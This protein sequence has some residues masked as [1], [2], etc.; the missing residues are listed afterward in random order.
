MKKLMIIAILLLVSNVVFSQTHYYKAKYEKPFT[1][2]V[3]PT[4]FNYGG[5]LFGYQI[6][7]NFKE[8]FN[9]SYFHTRDY[10]FGERYMD[11][12]FAGIQSSI[13]LPVGEYMQ[14]GPSVRLATYNTELQKVFIA[15]EV[16]LDLSD[17][18]KLGLE[19]GA[20]DKKGF[21]LK[22]IWNMY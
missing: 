9:L 2:Q 15:A 18:W 8:V 4:Y 11:D 3:A 12:R 22:F 1:F 19:Y 6:G 16:R 7:I 20:G 5:D 10:D 17:A 14:V 13:M 21:G